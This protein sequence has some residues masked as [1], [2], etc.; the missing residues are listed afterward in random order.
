M[1]TT[2]LKIP[3]L[4]KLTPQHR[5]SS[6]TERTQFRGRSAP[7]SPPGRGALPGRTEFLHDKT[8]PISGSPGAQTESAPGQAGPGRV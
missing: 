5:S 2:T 4:R 3:D 8:K 1:P 7:L 6:M